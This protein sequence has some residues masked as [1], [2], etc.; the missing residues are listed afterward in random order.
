MSSAV[1]DELELIVQLPD[2]LY[3]LYLLCWGWDGI[4][5]SLMISLNSYHIFVCVCVCASLSMCVFYFLNS[6]TFKTSLMNSAILRY[7]YS[8]LWE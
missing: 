8:T 4:D 2:R 5:L 6:N 1:S 3:N 7:S